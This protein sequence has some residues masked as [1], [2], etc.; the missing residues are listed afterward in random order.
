MKSWKTTIA[1]A[2]A[3]AATAINLIVQQGAKVED[4]K[5]WILPATIALFGFVSK[6]GNVTHSRR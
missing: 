3:A 5:T 1:G 2:L 4:W 6:D